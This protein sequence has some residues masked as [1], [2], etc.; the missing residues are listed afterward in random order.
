[1]TNSYTNKPDTNTNT[2]SNLIDLDQARAKK[3]RSRQQQVQLIPKTTNQERF[4]L[5]LL[6]SST[7]V[8]IATGPAGT[9]KTYLSTIAGIQALRNHEVDRIVLC[10]PSVSIEGENHG[11]LPGD[12]SSKLAP[13]LRPITDILRDFYSVSDIEH[14]LAEEIIEFASLGLI[15]GRTFRNT[16]LILDES[17]N[18]TPIQLKSLLTRIG[19][20]TKIIITGDIHQSDRRTPENGLQDLITRLKN[21]PIPGVSVCDFH[22]GDIQ[23][24]RLITEFINLYQQ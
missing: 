1:M 11:F 18:A 4:I 15:R 3:H 24:H 5:S 21:K 7:D 20:N 12:L 9:G 2:T 8:V 10:R 16:W 6:D 23:R 17:Q 14:M 22:A 13:W 19:E